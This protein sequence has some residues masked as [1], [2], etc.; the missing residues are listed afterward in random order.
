MSKNTTTK[1]YIT[2]QTKNL[3]QTP[4]CY[5]FRD[6][7]KEILYI[8]KAKKLR[9][10]VSSYFVKSHDLSPAKQKMVKLIDDIGYITVRS[11]AEALL[12]ESNLIKQ[13]QP[14]FN[15]DLKDDKFFQYIKIV[16]EKY[17][18]VITTRRIITDGSEYF[19]PYSSSSTIKNTLKFLK[20]ITP[21]RTSLKNDFFFDILNRNKKISETEYDQ[22]I[23]SLKNILK[24]NTRAAETWLRSKMQIAS[25]KKNYELAAVYRDRLNDLNKIIA[26]QQA[27]LKNQANIDVMA[28]TDFQH[29]IFITI[30]KIRNGKIIDKLNHK[31]KNPLNDKTEIFKSVIFDLYKNVANPPDI[32]ITPVTL[33]FSRTEIKTIFNKQIKII[34]PIRGR[35]KKLLELAQMNAEEFTRQNLPSFATTHDVASALQ[36]LQKNLKLTQIPKRIECYDISNIQGSHAVGAMIVFTN[37][38]AD[39]ARYRKFAIKYVMKDKPNDFAMIAEVMARRLQHTEWPTPNLIIIDGGKGQLSSAYRTMQ[40]FNTQSNSKFNNSKTKINIPIVSLAKKQEEIFVPDKSTSIKI[41][42]NTPAFFLIQRIRDEAHRFAITY[43]RLKHTKAL[44]K[45]KK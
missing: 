20:R 17:P 8:G 21:F 24:G 13:H 7:N 6:K 38:E 9:Q 45:G 1:N 19:G 10:R 23:K 15:I 33:Q 30:L 44:I 35:N 31:F 34:Y 40:N 29:S 5:V 26:P 27:I 37:G 39:K 42:K 4:G 2:K 11:E 25:R 28:A 3:P 43:Y 14:K 32:I 41:P 12:L 16:K 22:T 36:Q 18:R